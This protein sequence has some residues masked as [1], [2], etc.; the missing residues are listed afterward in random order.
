MQAAAVG[1]LHG[2]RDGEVKWFQGTEERLPVVD[3]VH[4]RPTFDVVDQKRVKLFG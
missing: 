3:S 4:L 1:N 2:V